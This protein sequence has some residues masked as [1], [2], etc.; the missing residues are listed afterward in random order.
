MDLMNKRL[1]V[2]PQIEEAEDMLIAAVLQQP[3]VIALIR[4]VLRPETL[5]RTPHSWVLQA[6]LLI[7]DRGWICSLENVAVML[8]SM[9]RLER[10]GG[11]DVLRGM[12]S[13][14]M[15]EPTIARGLALLIAERYQQFHHAETA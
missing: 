5:S 12:A 15:V 2:P 1:P 14:P 7:E 8:S 10:L 6:A 9:Q 3:E 13:L 4:G 11:V